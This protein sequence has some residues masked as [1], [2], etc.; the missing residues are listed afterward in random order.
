MN[1]PQTVID[2]AL[3]DALLDRVREKITLDRFDPNDH[4][5]LEQMVECL[6]DSRGVVRL[7]FAESLGE[8]GEPATPFLL[9]ALADH[10]NVVVRR[11]A[12]KTLTIIAD[13]TAIPGLL[14]ALLHDADTVVQGSSVGA[15]ARM[16]K[17]SVPVLMNILASPELPE[18]MQGHAAWALAFIGAEAKEILYQEMATASADVRYAIVGAIAKV[19]QDNPQDQQA[20]E[21]LMQSLNDDNANVRYEAASALGNLA[22]QPA[23]VP[24]T[25]LLQHSDW[26]TRKAATLSL[27]K[28]GVGSTTP[29]EMNAALTPLEAALPQEAVSA[30]QAV[31]KLAIT[32]ITNKLDD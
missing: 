31:L 17:A 22:Y 5:L 24:L 27:M 32:Q 25:T 28:I 23:I 2:P 19:A 7:A 29:M 4:A 3:S 14:H 6:G 26:E 20:F 1:S 21:I 30:V 8:I 9:T 15:L 10:P 16:G 12:A 11:A 13:T 18:S